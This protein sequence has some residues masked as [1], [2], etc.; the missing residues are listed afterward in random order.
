MD[1]S[2]PGAR[3]DGGRETGRETGTMLSSRDKRTERKRTD[4]FVKILG[5]GVLSLY[6]QNISTRDKGVSSGY[7]LSLLNWIFITRLIGR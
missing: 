1:E 2:R 4:G 6:D 7:L 5:I 3:L